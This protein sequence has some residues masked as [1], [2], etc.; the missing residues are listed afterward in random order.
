MPTVPKWLGNT[1]EAVFTAQMHPVQVTHTALISKQLKK[2]RFEGNLEKVGFKPGQVVEFR[3]TDTDYRHYTPSFFDAGNGVCEVLF[4]L[5]QM[6][7]GSDWAE[8]LKPG[9]LYKMLGPGGRLCYDDSYSHHFLFGDETSAG[10]FQCMEAAISRKGQSYFGLIEL[11]EKNKC[12][13]DDV[14]IPAHVVPKSPLQ[15]GMGAID[16]LSSWA[17]DFWEEAR[18]TCFYLTGRA[19]SIQAFKKLLLEKEIS[20]KQI[21]TEPYWADGK[22]GL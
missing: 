19:K 8:Q 1:L 9:D 11:D 18:Q 14:V 13:M 17:N 10:W 22:K 12:W 16:L 3:V 2:V 4:Y 7:V 15:P 20:P 5:H 21:R 6:G